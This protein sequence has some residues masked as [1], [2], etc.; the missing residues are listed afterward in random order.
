MIRYETKKRIWTLTLIRRF[1]LIPEWEFGTDIY[2]L[3]WLWFSVEATSIEW[4]NFCDQHGGGFEEMF[5]FILRE[6]E[7]DE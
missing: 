4:L 3:T 2:Y 6:I 1:Y 5:D 7:E